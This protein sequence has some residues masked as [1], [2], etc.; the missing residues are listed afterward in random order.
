MR[1]P[2]VPS[3]T[4]QPCPAVQPCPPPI[5]SLYSMDYYALY[6]M[7]YLDQ[8][9][10]QY[11]T[12]L[13]ISSFPRGPLDKRVTRIRY[14]KL[15]PFKEESPKCVLAITDEH[16]NLAD[17]EQFPELLG[18]LSYHQYQIDFS[19]TKM[20]QKADIDQKGKTLICYISRKN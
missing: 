14:P 17:M 11:R 10:R 20:L 9:E 5:I 16:G 7:P 8:R 6:R 1:A 19:V 2:T 3:P 4:V 15:S 18:F 13:S 12:I